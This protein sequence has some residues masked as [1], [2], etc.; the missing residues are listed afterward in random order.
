MGDSLKKV[1]SGDPLVIPAQTFNTFVD[2]ARD[3]QQRAQNRGQKAQP[4]FR[5][6]GIVP[7]KNVSGYDC[8]R[9]DVL[10][11]DSPVFT[12]TDS[13]DAFKNQVALK[14]NTPAANRDLPCYS[15]KH[16]SPGLRQAGREGVFLRP[17][18]TGFAYGEPGR[19]VA[20]TGA[21]GNNRIAPIGSW[22]FRICF[23]F[24]PLFAN[25]TA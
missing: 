25:L 3:Y 16:E 22:W 8:G 24:S 15:A 14:N 12:P 9:F 7:V 19:V 5:Q 2:A 6:T 20:G 4:G 1:Q 11:I 21:S 23:T 18:A 13:L 10:G 17:D